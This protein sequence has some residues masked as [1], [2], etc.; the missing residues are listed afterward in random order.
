MNYIDVVKQLMDYDV[1]LG[2]VISAYR[3]L[4]TGS[5]Q[6]YLFRNT[7]LDPDFHKVEQ[8][9]AAQIDTQTHADVVQL[10]Q[11][12][13][14]SAGRGN[15]FNIQSL[16]AVIE[17]RL[18][19]ETPKK[20]IISN[21]PP[22]PWDVGRNEEDVG[23]VELI[24]ANGNVFL[25]WVGDEYHEVFMKLV[26][27]TP[28]IVEEVCKVVRGYLPGTVQTEAIIGLSEALNKAGVYLVR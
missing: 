9:Q 26:I 10:I 13:W 8:R 6:E 20:S 7:V 18:G 25:I 4:G 5:G 28:E 27:A 23:Q 14:D 17:G 11:D 21:L 24:D 19:H 2:K 12:E 22:Q 1:S 15:R 16:A 3:D